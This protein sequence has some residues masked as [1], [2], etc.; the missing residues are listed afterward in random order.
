MVC[1]NL[2]ICAC[3]DRQATTEPAPVVSAAAPSAPAAKAPDPVATKPETPVATGAVV[4]VASLE[5]APQRDGVALPV[6]ALVGRGA[7]VVLANGDRIAL[8][9]ARSGRVA[10]EG[11]AMLQLGVDSDGQ[12]LAAAGVITVVVPPAGDGVLIAQRLA[13]PR[14]T[15]TFRPGTTAVVAI[16]RNGDA[17][18]N[19][20]DGVATVLPTSLA[21][22]ADGTVDGQAADVDRGSAQRFDARGVTMLKPAEDLTAALALGR[23]FAATPPRGARPST[24]DARRR[25]VEECLAALAAEV[26]QGKQLELGHKQ[27]IA[28]G[29]KDA[30]V[31]IQRL[32]AAHGQRLFRIRRVLLERWE[33][34]EV[35]WLTLDPE[36]RTTFTSS[37]NELRTAVATSLP[38]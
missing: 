15:F 32:L 4:R 36:R 10:V 30:R 26:T 16:D 19:V 23:K 3:G 28:A 34:V 22:D 37:L 27:A 29:D 6:G 1:W 7:I 18:V 20:I 12:L 17:L 21:V 9:V 5:G 13:I 2:T 25:A 14:S 24:L 33:R 35:A 31:T 38:R 8:D 11:P